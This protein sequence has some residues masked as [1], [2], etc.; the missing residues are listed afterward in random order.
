MFRG[1]ARPDRVLGSSLLSGGVLAPSAANEDLASSGPASAHNT[2]IKSGAFR[3]EARPDRLL[4][5]S[6]RGDVPASSLFGGCSL[7]LGLS[8]V[9]FAGCGSQDNFYACHLGLL[10]Q[11]SVWNIFDAGEEVVEIGCSAMGGVGG[12]LE[13]VASFNFQ[14]VHC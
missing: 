11:H 9:C 12:G 7:F 1:E 13:D 5:L 3:G 4:D 6:Y 8:S 10:Q 2:T 14:L